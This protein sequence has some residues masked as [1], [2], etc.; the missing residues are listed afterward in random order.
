MQTI[1]SPTMW[2]LLA[3]LACTASSSA[4]NLPDPIPTATFFIS[5][6]S[7][8]Q[9]GNTSLAP[10]SSF[11]EGGSLCAYVEDADILYSCPAGDEQ[12]DSYQCLHDIRRLT[13]SS[14]YAGTLVANAQVAMILLQE[15]IKQLVATLVLAT[16]SGVATETTEIVRKLHTSRTIVGAGFRIR[17][18]ESTPL[19]HR[20]QHQS[21][22]RSR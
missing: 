19:R 6:S 2:L 4:Q 1:E 14:E 13:R 11:E 7:R 9:Y 15:M 22:C 8:C 17:I 3:I 10:G 12:V 20:H 5:L 16:L 18:V 21:P